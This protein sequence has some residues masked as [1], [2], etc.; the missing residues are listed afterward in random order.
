MALSKQKKH[1]LV[2]EMS[3][4]LKSSKLTVIAKYEGTT[5]KGMQELRRQ[6]RDSG[7]KVKVVKN[8]LVIKALED[9]EALKDV[10]T[11][12]LEGM[13]LY[14]FNNEDEVAPA[15]SLNEFAKKS[16]T[17]EFVGAIMPDGKQLSADEVKSL[18][19][20]PGKNDLIAQVLATLASPLNDAISGLSGNLHGLLDGVSAKAEA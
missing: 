20:L 14:A 15:Q 11:S 10:D 7:T 17:I 9:T 4:L 12:A 5:V 8:R 2:S 3:D 18:A 16:P 6:A 13:L 19:S 1:E